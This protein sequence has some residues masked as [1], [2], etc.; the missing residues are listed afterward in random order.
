MR[1][2]GPAVLLTAIGSLALLLTGFG[3]HDGARTTIATAT[4]P[5]TTTAPS[6]AE[7]MAMAPRTGGAQTWSENCM[8]C[9]NYRRP[10]G[11]SDR[12][13]AAIVHH[14]RV[15]ANLTADEHRLILRFLQA[16]N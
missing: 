10:R 14:M 6:D 1:R 16:A 7:A 8:R 9:H 4:R 12:E 15:R 5:T 13:W 3:C 11:R 2:S